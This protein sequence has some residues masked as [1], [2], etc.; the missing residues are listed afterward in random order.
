MFC[1]NCGTKFDDGAKFCPSCGTAVVGDVDTATVGSGTEDADVTVKK[2]KKPAMAAIVCAV[3]SIV[4]CFL[5]WIIVPTGS[6]FKEGWYF[7]F[8][9]HEIIGDM[10]CSNSVYVIYIIALFSAFLLMLMSIVLYI[11][12]IIGELRRKNNPLTLRLASMISIILAVVAAGVAI[13][14]GIVSKGDALAYFKEGFLNM[15]LNNPVVSPTAIVLLVLAVVNM[16]IA[17]TGKMEEV[18]VAAEPTPVPVAV[19]VAAAVVNQ[20]VHGAGYVQSGMNTAADNTAWSMPEQTEEPVQ[21]TWEAPVLEEVPFMEEPVAVE[22]VPAV[23]EPVAA[24]EVPAVEEPMAVEEAPVVEEPVAVEEAPAVEEPVAT[25]AD[26]A[27]K[28]PVSN[29]T[30]FSLGGDL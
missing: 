16:F 21:D 23:E 18:A 8:N 19:P 6:R 25:D 28:P 13:C 30:A 17:K 5:P 29:S 15:I 12:Y 14:M 27:P 10:P 9:M 3:L 20:P 7:V 24:E 4:M 26:T 22:E 2:Q 11:W 1:R